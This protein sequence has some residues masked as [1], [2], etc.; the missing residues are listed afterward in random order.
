MKKGILLLI[1]LCTV[2]LSACSYSILSNSCTSMENAPQDISSEIQDL[3]SQVIQAIES[4]SSDAI[5]AISSEKMKN[6]ATVLK[7]FVSRANVSLT[8]TP[9]IM[10]NYYITFSN[11]GTEMQA[12]TPSL[13]DTPYYLCLQPVSKEMAI[14]FSTFTVDQTTL[15][16][17]EI[18]V[19]NDTWQL[20]GLRVSA[21]AYNGMNA[22]EIYNV[23]I[24]YQKEGQLIPAGLYADLYTE[25]MQ[26]ADIIVY[27]TAEE[28]INFRNKISNQVDEKYTFPIN[29]DTQVGSYQVS[30]L[31]ITM[32]DNGLT[33]ILKYVTNTSLENTTQLNKE[34][35]AIIE[36]VDEY[37][38]GYTE[39]MDAYIVGAFNEIPS[40]PNKTYPYYSTII[41]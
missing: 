14:I 27:P 35:N 13:K 19:K 16:L 25:I 36:V 33:G 7:D 38:P 28:M 37:F 32:T 21:Y 23:A 41:E 1:C 18:Y 26:P 9:K 30:H 2:M 22:P 6:D 24:Q 11:T 3:H 17:V 5:L 4:D 40:D 10:D 20:E 34:A 8:E 39:S 29:F 15:L 12:L 31:S